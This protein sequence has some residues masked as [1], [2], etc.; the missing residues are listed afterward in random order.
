MGPLGGIAFRH[1]VRVAL[2]EQALAAALFTEPGD[3]V[4]ASGRDVLDLEVE[5]L[6]ANQ[7]STW[8]ATAAS[9]ASASPGRTTLDIRIR[10][11]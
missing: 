1:D 9:V 7:A 8:W 5:P 6:L 11:G 3:D 2:E 4:R 10:L